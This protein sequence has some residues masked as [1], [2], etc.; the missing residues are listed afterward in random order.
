[1][2]PPHPSWKKEIQT[3]RNGHP[4]ATEQL[5]QQGGA[6]KAP[7]W[8]FG[9]K[10]TGIVGTVNDLGPTGIGNP[11]DSRYPTDPVFTFGVPAGDPRASQ[12]RLNRGRSAPPGPNFLPAHDPTTP[13]WSFGTTKRPDP[14]NPFGVK[15]GP[16]PKDI[17][18]GPGGPKYS[19]PPGPQRDSGYGPGDTPSPD[20][21][22]PRRP[23]KNPGPR[24]GPGTV[25][26]T[27]PKNPQLG[28][29][30]NFNPLPFRGGPAYSFRPQ[31]PD[32]GDGMPKGYHDGWTLPPQYTYFGY[33]E[34]GHC[35]T[36]DIVNIKGH[37]GRKDAK[38]PDGRPMTKDDMVKLRKS[39]SMPAGKFHV[40]R[41]PIDDH[42]VRVAMTE[43]LKK[44]T[45]QSAA[46]K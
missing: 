1:M 4:H 44:L 26:D 34:F 43:K 46:T 14:F 20:F 38:H 36:F 37:L 6:W 16:G 2:G 21:Y 27:I 24:Y 41:P 19:F 11:P 8:T 5:C 10:V 31:L 12:S 13:K 32:G 17:R 25:L 18:G 7:K 42:P 15:S 29:G 9:Q 22:G 45:E 35:D 3:F 23:E 40:V 33:N 30:P 28:I 39:V